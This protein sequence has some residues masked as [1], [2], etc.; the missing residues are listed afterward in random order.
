MDISEDQRSAV[1]QQ[2]VNSMVDALKN[3]KLNNEDL[4]II[5]QFILGKIDS[6]Q[7]TGQLVSFLGELSQRWPVFK[8]IAI[9]ESGNVRENQEK[10]AV[11][12]VLSLT[13]QGNI[14]EA[15]NLAKKMTNN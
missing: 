12:D 6:I 8:N 14:D 3:D 1:E 9:I 4:P 13:Q 7:N 15:L 10:E 2:I 5:S 11:R